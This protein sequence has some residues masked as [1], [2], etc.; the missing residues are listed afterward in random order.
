MTNKHFPPHLEEK[1]RD[2][3]KEHFKVSDDGNIFHIRSGCFNGNGLLEP[4]TEDDIKDV[5]LA[6][7]Q[8]LMPELREALNTIK[9]SVDYLNSCGY[10][11]ENQAPD[12]NEPEYEM[13]KS[14]QD[15]AD[16]LKKL[17]GEGDGIADN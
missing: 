9:T 4:I 17:I 14:L 10:T 2:Y 16:K 12:F 15:A 3:I 11:K 13:N 7:F 6:A 8:L 5:F 1:M